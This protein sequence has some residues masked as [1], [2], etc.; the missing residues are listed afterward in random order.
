[1]TKLWIVYHRFHRGPL[2]EGTAVEHFDKTPT[3]VSVK[4]KLTCLRQRLRY[5]FKHFLP[6]II[7]MYSENVSLPLCNFIIS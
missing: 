7:M 5:F 1:V 2:S 6:E 4:E 3:F